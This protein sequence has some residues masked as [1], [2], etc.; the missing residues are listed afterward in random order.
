VSRSDAS[1]AGV[2]ASFTCEEES[3]LNDF[4]LIEALYMPYP[5]VQWKAP[6]GAEGLYAAQDQ[7]AR[8]G[9]VIV[10]HLHH[11]YSIAYGS[12]AFFL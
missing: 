12:T 9:S 5:T 10:N 3:I 1:A 2:D 6:S 8:D 4:V 7:A 11:L